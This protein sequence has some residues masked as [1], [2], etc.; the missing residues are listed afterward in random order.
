M[1]DAHGK[2]PLRPAGDSN[3]G[4]GRVQRCALRLVDSSSRLLDIVFV[5]SE[6][7]APRR[8]FTS[9]GKD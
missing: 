4:V 9:A 7:R 5:R 8:N 6:R 3:D 1:V 2:N